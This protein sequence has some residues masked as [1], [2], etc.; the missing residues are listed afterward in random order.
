MKRVL[1]A[2]AALTLVA[3]CQRRDETADAPPA[4]PVTGAPET[5]ADDSAV[6]SI[7]T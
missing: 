5:P 7:P 1:A 4:T 2:L 3:A 6:P